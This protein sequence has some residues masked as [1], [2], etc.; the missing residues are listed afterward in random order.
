MKRFA[1]D[2][3]KVVLLKKTPETKADDHEIALYDV[4]GLDVVMTTGEGKLSQKDEKETQVYKRALEKS[5]SLKMKASRGVF[6]DI[7]KRF[8]SFTLAERFLEGLRSASPLIIISS[9]SAGT[10][11]A[12]TAT[13]WCSCPLHSCC[14][15]CLPR[16]RPTGI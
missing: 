7:C 12:T 11:R 8:P 2:G 1:I 13:R 5:Y 4:F 6:S 10:L 14:A 3:N 9:R 15:T 16:S